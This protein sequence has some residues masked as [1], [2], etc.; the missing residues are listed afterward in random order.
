MDVA[1][2]KDPAEA[3]TAYCILMRDSATAVIGRKVLREE[4]PVDAPPTGNNAKALLRR[5]DF[6]KKEF[7]PLLRAERRQSTKKSK[8]QSSRSRAKRR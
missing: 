4:F 1:A 8:R 2:I 6:L 7:V 5:V 3:L